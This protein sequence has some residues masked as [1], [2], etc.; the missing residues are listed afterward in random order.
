MWPYEKPRK[1]IEPIAPAFVIELHD[2]SP[3]TWSDYEALVE[4]FAG[5]PEVRFSHLL[6]PDYHYRGRFDRYPAFLMKMAERLDKGDEIVLHGYSHL[7]EAP[8]P[9][10]PH[11][12]VERRIR[13][14]EGEFAALTHEQAASRIQAGSALF[15]KMGWPLT[16][17]VPPGWVAGRQARA[18][19]R[20][21]GFR[22]TASA[23]GMKRL[24]DGA[25]QRMPPLVWSAR[26]PW[27]R[28]L[29]EG[30]NRFL[31]FYH[32]QAPVIRLALHPVDMRHERPR[33]LW[34][35]SIRLLRR[36]RDCLTKDEV[37]ALLR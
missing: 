15:Q 6:V 13:T 8:P 5:D 36:Y 3:H 29:S 19:I 18:A 21:A 31:R 9:R 16:G 32:A 22:Y 4:A 11:Q 35:E 28:A 7:D 27:R 14:H 24:P 26:A 2:V 23:L 34:W 30:V 33:S 12:F 17:F 37:A 20:E 25:F 1:M 10:W